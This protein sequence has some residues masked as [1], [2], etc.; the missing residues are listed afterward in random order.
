VI[1][2][3]EKGYAERRVVIEQRMMENRRWGSVAWGM[4]TTEMSCVHSP[5]AI[6]VVPP[7]H[8]QCHLL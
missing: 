2:E 1:E 7:H 8:T 5:H 6:E 4:A 3:V